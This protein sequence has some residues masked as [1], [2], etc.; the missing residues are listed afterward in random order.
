M[1]MP[2]GVAASG[3]RRRKRETSASQQRTHFQ[4]IIHFDECNNTHRAANRKGITRGWFYD[5]AVRVLFCWESGCC[6]FQTTKI[7]FL[8]YMLL[9][10]RVQHR[11]LVSF[12]FGR[13]FQSRFDDSVDVVDPHPVIAR[14]HVWVCGVLVVNPISRALCH[15]LAPRGVWGGWW[16][17]RGA[18]SRINIWKLKSSFDLTGMKN[19]KQHFNYFVAKRFLGSTGDGRAGRTTCADFYLVCLCGFLFYGLRQS[20]AFRLKWLNKLILG[21]LQEVRCFSFK[22]SLLLRSSPTG[23]DCRFQKSENEL[24]ERGKWEARD[25]LDFNCTFLRNF[26]Q[27]NG[28][29]FAGK[30]YSCTRV[31]SLRKTQD[32]FR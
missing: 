26:D 16:E 9:N 1:T 19:I 5:N 29:R 7:S 15:A 13:S 17:R 32:V 22:F 3:R 28:M 14:V 2:C 6:D 25:V 23:R 11:S 8:V 31:D 24:Y 21:R 27:R 4:S 18:D 20:F 30:L 12:P 10:A